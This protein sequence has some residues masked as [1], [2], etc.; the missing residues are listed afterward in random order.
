MGA[1]VCKH[2]ELGQWA[3]VAKWIVST[4]VCMSL[5][6]C[7]TMI[8]G[9]SQTITMETVPSGKK[10]SFSGIECKAPQAITV[11][12]HFE[13]PWVMSGNRLAYKTDIPYNLSPW[14]WGDVGMCLF[15]F[16]PGAHLI[17][18]FGVVGLGVDVATGSFRRYETITT[19]PGGDS[20]SSD[21]EDPAPVK[22]KGKSGRAV[23]PAKEE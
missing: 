7:A 14:I 22:S 1:M 3:R 9:T 13:A 5:F 17:G 12:K 8:D 20:G 10:F 23:N 18:V 6:G 4:T 11:Q 21:D 2:E 19:I 16:V 15:F